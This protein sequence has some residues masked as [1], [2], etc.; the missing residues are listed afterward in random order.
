MVTSERDDLTSKN[1]ELKTV[2]VEAEVLRKKYDDMVNHLV[3]PSSMSL[4]Y[5][6]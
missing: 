5:F 1:E 6:C 2:I 4:A 3:F